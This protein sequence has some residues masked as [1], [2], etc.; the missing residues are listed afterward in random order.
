MKILFF[1][2]I[3]KPVVLIVLG[4]NLRNREKLPMSGPAII[5]ANHNS[6]LDTLVLM[7][8]YPLSM[9]HKVRP[10]A[11]ADYFLGNGGFLAWLSLV[12]IG[13]IGMDRSGKSGKE[14]LF[15]GCHQALD[16]NDILILFPEGSR[17]KPEEMS[18][19]KKGVYFIVKDRPHIPVTPVMMHGLGRSLPKGE[20]LLVPFNCDVVVGNSV[21]V[22]DNS[23][24]YVDA[25]SEQFKQL[26]Q[27][28]L[29][30]SDTAEESL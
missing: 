16:N 5:V 15:K 12:C 26:S 7:S 11:A 2:L 3:V 6:H 25:I 1:A 30:K 8:L 10:V 27:Y 19:L 4:I 20:V 14:G 22:T 9:I 28:C 23:S 17:G 18:A 13:I 21:P 29:T 24:S